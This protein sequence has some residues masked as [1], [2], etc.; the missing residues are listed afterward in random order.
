MQK[1]TLLNSR[2]ALKNHINKQ[3][4]LL[5]GLEDQYQP[6]T[7]KIENVTQEIKEIK[8][9]LPLQLENGKVIQ[10]A[11]PRQNNQLSDKEKELWRRIENIKNTRK[12]KGTLRLSENQGDTRIYYI[13]DRLVSINNNLVLRSIDGLELKLNEGLIELFFLST[14][15]AS[16]F[17]VEDIRNYKNF[18]RGLG[19]NLNMGTQ[20][21]KIIETK[22]HSAEQVRG[23]GL[24]AIR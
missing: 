22:R 21:Q 5:M 6:I 9:L 14:P 17:D 13:G 10:V 20:K 24:A 18:I 12:E 1:I 16:K 15:D 7:S 8:E 19:L 11:T 3:K 2:K 23:Q 4:L